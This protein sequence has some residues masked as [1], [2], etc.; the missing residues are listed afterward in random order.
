MTSARREPVPLIV[1]TL[2]A[3]FTVMARGAG[4]Q[5]GTPDPGGPTAIEQALIEHACTLSLTLAA[6]TAEHQQC[7]SAQLLSLRADFGRDLSRL[8][9][10]ER[11]TLDSVCSK[12]RDA[13]GREAYLECLSA[14]LLA[15]RNR[16]SRANP[17]ASE[18]AAAPPPPVVSVPS[19]SP[20]AP[21]RQASSW[22]SGLWIGAT[23]LTLIVVAGAVLLAAKARRPPRTCRV[24]GG[25]VPESGD[26]CQKCRHDAA[27]AVRFA[28]AERADQ[29][30]A[31][32]EEQRRLSEREEEQRRQ[33]TRQEEEAPLRQQEEARQQEKDARQREEEKAASQPSLGAIASQEVFDPYAVL[34]VLR[35]ASKEDILAAYQQAKLKYDPDQVTYLSAEVQEHFK[36]KAQEVD[37]AHQKLIE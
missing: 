9:G 15:L 16:R 23:L 29:Q 8:S 30:R 26:L 32:Q 7:L 28:A 2:M 17:A 27:E 37:R 33:K 11:R 19:F 10:P 24:C 5:V 20:P 25:D 13:R 35:D 12:I 6:E 4:L 34:G 22:S 18:A 3:A 1:W 36:A 21:V 14:Q 31:Q